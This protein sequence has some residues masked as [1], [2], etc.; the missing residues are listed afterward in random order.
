MPI[1]N[2]DDKPRNEMI[3]NVIKSL[4]YLPLSTLDFIK[5][6]RGRHWNLNITHL[7][8]NNLQLKRIGTL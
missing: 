4:N 3:Q 8:L 1:F 5:S 6:K 7:T 2:N